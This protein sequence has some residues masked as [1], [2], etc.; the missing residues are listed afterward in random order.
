MNHQES[1]TDP[2]Y[3]VSDIMNQALSDEQHKSN[4]LEKKL[5]N[6]NYN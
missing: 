5:K 3:D 4:Y 6:M 2:C 1:Q